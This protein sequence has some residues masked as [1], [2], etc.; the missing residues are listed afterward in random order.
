MCLV[1]CKDRWGPDGGL[2]VGPGGVTVSKREGLIHNIKCGI[3]LYLLHLQRKS[4]NFESL[5][6]T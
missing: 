2:S 4:V 6:L 3:S 5:L 1:L